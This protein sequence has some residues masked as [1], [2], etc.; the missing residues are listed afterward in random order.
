[1]LRIEKFDPTKTYMFVNGSLATPEA[2]RK[3]NP[4][5][6]SFTHVLELNGDVVQA[7]M[8]LS[9]LRGIHKIDNSLTDDEAIL[10]IETITNTP[11]PIV[12]SPQE[13]TA[14]AME[15]TNLMML[16][17]VVLSE[18]IIPEGKKSITID[19][20]IVNNDPHAKLIKQN[21]DRGLWNSKM[22]EK[23]KSKGVL[24]TEQTSVIIDSSI[25]V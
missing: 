3:A 13:R 22:V 20:S 23:A 17:D 18:S 15:F 21:Y 8:N 25:I 1:M 10:A 16:D 7:I 12:I 19:K 14:A 6:D 24:S 2:I 4:A 5:I 11:A 9:A